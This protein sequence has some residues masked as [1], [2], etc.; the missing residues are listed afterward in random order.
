MIILGLKNGHD[1]AMAVIEERR[2]TLLVEPEK[3]SFPR[4]HPLTPD[5]VLAAASHLGRIPDVIAV[6]GWHLQGPLGPRPVGAGYFGTDVAPLRAMRLFGSPIRFFAS[7]HER[8]HIMMALGMAPA[9]DAD[10]QAVLVWE[11]DIG[12]LYLVDERGNLLER[13]AVLSHP[14]ARYAFLYALADPSFPE[15]AAQ[16]RLEDA[17]KLM[18][19]VGYGREAS[20]DREISKTVNEI[21]ALESLYPQPKARFRRSPL[22]NAGVEAEAV[23]D[24]ARLL[25]DRLFRRFEQAAEA[26]FPPGLPLRISG[27]CGLNCDWNQRWLAG[28][29]F[30]T[31]FVPPCTDDSG[32]AAGTG[33][34]ALFAL[35]GDPRVT[36]NVYAGLEF[37]I[38]VQPAPERWH[39]RP[40]NRAAL[41]DSLASGRIVAWVQGRCEIGPRALGNRSL[42]ADPSSASTRKRLNTI[43]HRERFRPIAP[44]CR[45]EE[46][47]EHFDPGFP[48]PYM[49]YFQ[50]VRS[51]QLQAVTHVDGTARV[52]SVTPEDNPALHALLCAV[53]ARSGAGVLCNTS[54]NIKGRGF[55]NRMSD[56]ALLAETSGIDD[57]VV[58][59]TWFERIPQRR[60]MVIDY[61]LV[62][63]SGSRSR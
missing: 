47:T 25:S 48:D 44:C 14:G 11:G 5:T 52:Q 51:A 17:G 3:N 27:G 30:S 60:S 38:D 29:Y 24:A 13:R 62:A 26:F 20:P 2:L 56:L 1:G 9:D 37:D 16:P 46:L 10:R 42:L 55:V 15:S 12:S 21:L 54:L 8:S 18:A 4:H 59:E 50:R 57:L 45:S 43:K 32:S 23:A 49:L 33:I 19:L 58:G 39:K 41:A 34:D 22:Y 6:G 53:A 40:L 31:V 61:G 63:T 35:T 36:W 28:G 7:S